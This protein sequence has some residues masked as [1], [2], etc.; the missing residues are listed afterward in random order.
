MTDAIHPE[1]ECCANCVNWSFYKHPEYSKRKVFIGTCANG[2][3]SPQ[4]PSWGVDFT[5][6]GYHCDEFSN[7]HLDP[8]DGRP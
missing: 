6:A 1:D 2:K 4:A 3:S 5:Y 7:D 8:D